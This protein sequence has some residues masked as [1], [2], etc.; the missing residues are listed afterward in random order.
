MKRLLL[1]RYCVCVTVILLAG[2]GNRDRGMQADG[3]SIESRKAG[4]FGESRKTRM[5]RLAECLAA[6]SARIKPQ[7]TELV[8]PE[9][10]KA[11]LPFDML[12]LKRIRLSAGRPGPLG[13]FVSE[14]VAD[15]ECGGDASLSVRLIDLGGMTN[16]STLTQLPWVGVDIDR[17][18]EVGHEKTRTLCGF[19]AFEEF[20]GSTETTVIQIVLKKRLLVEIETQHMGAD[21]ARS[22]VEHIPLAALGGLVP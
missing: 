21:E 19:Q 2:C 1:E 6:S 8:N 12:G 4:A 3:P 14:V 7:E 9:D 10:M 5:R 18:T 16:L 15:Y 13:A 22:A 11:M 17:Q 20:D